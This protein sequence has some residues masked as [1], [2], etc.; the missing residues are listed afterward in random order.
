MSE[1][2]V[3][4]VID[5]KDIGYSGV[6]KYLLVDYLKE[7]TG[8]VTIVEPQPVNLSEP[9]L[10]LMYTGIDIDRGPDITGYDTEQLYTLRISCLL[11]LMA[12]GDGPD[13]FLDSVIKAS[14]I[15]RKVFDKPFNIELPGV[16][17]IT[18]EGKRRQGG[19]LF[20]NEEEGKKPYLY[21]ENYD[22]N[23]FIPYVEAAN[24]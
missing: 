12:Y 10:R 13:R 23:I 9:H 17:G 8:L 22:V 18:V 24:A 6:I 1:K 2:F 16:H 7:K 11:T 20:R 15:L 21:E 14:F 19:Q 3:K 4:E 5:V